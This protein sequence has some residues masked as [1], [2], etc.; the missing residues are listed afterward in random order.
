[1][2]TK[3]IW[4][5]QLKRFLKKTLKNGGDHLEILLNLRNGFYKVW[6]V[7][8]YDSCNLSITEKDRMSIDMNMFS[9]IRRDTYVSSCIIPECGI[10]D[11][12]YNKIMVHYPCNGGLMGFKL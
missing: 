11:A 1:M 6:E 8:R 3:I 12:L 5:G 7:Q 4:K 9:V 2:L 10:K